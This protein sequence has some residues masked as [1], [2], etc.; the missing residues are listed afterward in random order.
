MLTKDSVTVSVDAAV[1]FRLFNFKI[2][3]YFR[4]SDP[5]A[6]INSIVDAHLSTRQLTQ[7]TLRNVLGTRTLT[8]IM[9][10]REGI[11]RQAQEVL[12]E[13]IRLNI[14]H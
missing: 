12:D 10:D 4:A 13:G 2:N 8:E 7:T 11:A 6:T 3:L 5:I 14:F 1:Y 9:I